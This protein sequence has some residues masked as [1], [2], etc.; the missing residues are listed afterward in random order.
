MALI[1]NKSFRT[2]RQAVELLL[3]DCHLLIRPE[4]ADW[5]SYGRIYF[6]ESELKEK[7]ESLVDKQ[8]SKIFG[9]R[10]EWYIHTEYI[11]APYYRFVT[12]GCP[13]YFDFNLHLNHVSSV[14]VYWTE[15][16]Y[17]YSEK[18]VVIDLIKKDIEK[19]KLP[20]DFLQAISTGNLSQF[21]QR[22]RDNQGYFT[23][24]IPSIDQDIRLHGVLLRSLDNA[25]QGKPLGP[26]LVY[27]GLLS[28][29][30]GRLAER[31]LRMLPSPTN[32][33]PVNDKAPVCSREEVKEALTGKSL[34]ITDRNAANA[35]DAVF[36]PSLTLEENVT[37]CLQYIGRQ[38]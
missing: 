17:A 20:L 38:P 13:H 7:S 21:P 26:A 30:E 3:R 12:S 34:G 4:V 6:P 19:L 2:R 14:K 28:D 23:W 31:S 35:L 15:D 29:S 5:F 36:D 33:T 8:V 1:R 11:I 37:H 24:H 18:C 16:N 32:S 22:E 10:A 27:Y 9:R 25:F